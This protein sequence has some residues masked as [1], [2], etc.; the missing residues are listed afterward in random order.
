M[1]HERLRARAQ[2]TSPCSYGLS[3]SQNVYGAAFENV[4]GAARSP[5]VVLGSCPVRREDLVELGQGIF[6]HSDLERANRRVKLLFGS[7]SDDRRCHCRARQ[8][9]SDR[10]VCRLL[11]ELAAQRFVSLDLRFVPLTCTLRPVAVAPALF[12][13]AATA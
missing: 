11:A 13:T 10:D 12:R 7:G 3:V 5:C 9:P 2:G 8:E 1:C 6:V 4:Y